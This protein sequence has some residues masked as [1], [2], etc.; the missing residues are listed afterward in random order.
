MKDEVIG[1]NVVAAGGAE[2][3]EGSDRAAQAA[4]G[5]DEAY[6]MQPLPKLNGLGEE[7]GDDQ[8]VA[9]PPDLVPG[10]VPDL[11]HRAR[12]GRHD[13]TCPEHGHEK[14]EGGILQ[15]LEGGELARGGTGRR[16]G[17]QEVEED[18]GGDGI[19]AADRAGEAAGGTANDGEKRSV[20]GRT[21]DPESSS[22]SVDP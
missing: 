5:G 9:D 14:D 3:I 4:R 11:A 20:F 15:H 16:T 7:D 18:L 10:Q 12:V 2:S 17:P 13:I 8:G 21:R 19:T 22:G 1:E 6:L